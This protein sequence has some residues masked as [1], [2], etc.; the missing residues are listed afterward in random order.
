MKIAVSGEG[1]ELTDR[2]DPRFGRARGFILHDTETG[3]SEYIDNKQNLDS[4]QGAG[5]Q[6]AGNV[7]DAGAE[8]VITGNVG[9]KAYAALKSASVPVYLFSEGSIGDAITAFKNGE[10]EK[11]SEANVE[12]HW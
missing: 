2:V 7:I 11:T 9:P 1:R 4:A 5:I 10:L 3:R 8:A 12:G 6:S